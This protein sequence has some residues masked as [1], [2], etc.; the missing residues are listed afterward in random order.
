MLPRR[1]DDRTLSKEKE[2]YIPGLVNSHN[3]EDSTE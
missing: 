1:K 2:R 3:I